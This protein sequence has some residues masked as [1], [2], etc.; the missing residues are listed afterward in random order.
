MSRA[1]HAELPLRIVVCK[2][3]P[4]VAFAIQLGKDGLITPTRVTPE[5]LL[6]DVSVRVASAPIGSAPRL[7]GPVVQGPAG[8]RFLYV[9]SGVRAGQE[10]SVW[11]RR[12]KV[13]LTGLTWEL[14]RS[15]QA[16]PGSRLEARIAGTGRDGG[17]SCATVP[18]LGEGWQVVAG[19]VL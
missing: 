7:L 2:P 15:H 8:A 14:L 3:P 17:P 10:G 18:L 9:S 6:F 12:A 5:A 11:D 16:T 19:A 4:G 1:D 13:P